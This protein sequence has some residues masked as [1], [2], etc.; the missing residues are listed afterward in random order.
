MPTFIQVTPFHNIS[1][2]AHS[3]EV[4]QEF[5]TITINTD[6]IVT[7]IKPPDQSNSSIT[8]D[9][10]IYTPT[11]IKL[12]TGD[13]IKACETYDWTKALAC[14]VIIRAGGRAEVNPYVQGVP[15][16]DRRFYEL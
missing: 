2:V 4:I 1:D 14:S 13:V 15:K 16:I 9:G 7:I 8:F 6:H 5:A 11:I 10:L 3:V 12:V